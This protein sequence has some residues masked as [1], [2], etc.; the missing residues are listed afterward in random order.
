MKK[1]SQL[2]TFCLLIT[3]VS[4][5]SDNKSDLPKSSDK[6]GTTKKKTTKS[7]TPA[8]TDSRRKLSIVMALQNGNAPSKEKIELQKIF[9]KGADP[10][11][12]T[13]SA[14]A[15]VN[16]L[17]RLEYLKTNPVKEPSPV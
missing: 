15:Y 13:A 11:I 9:G 2:L 16:G 17:N 6:K 12:I 14:R 5:G 10:D 4:C 8:L 3:A 1:I 7:S